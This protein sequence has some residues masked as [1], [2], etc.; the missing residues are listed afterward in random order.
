MS[1]HCLIISLKIIDKLVRNTEN[2]NYGGKKKNAR[3]K[4]S[5]QARAKEVLK[6]NDEIK[7]CTMVATIR[8]RFLLQTCLLMT[9]NLDTPPLLCHRYYKFIVN[10]TVFI[11][12]VR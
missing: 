9:F 3:R 11:Q 1:W 6:T 5:L 2:I 12:P 4:I 7:I 8:V 10:K